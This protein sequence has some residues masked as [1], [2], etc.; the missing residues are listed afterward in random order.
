MRSVILALVLVASPALAGPPQL[1]AP[2]GTYLGNLST[3]RFDPNSI[4]NPY[5]RYGSPYSPYS[6]NNLYGRYGSQYSPDSPNNPYAIGS[7]YSMASN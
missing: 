6:I 1:Y 3:N 5:G 4:S 7:P 2:D